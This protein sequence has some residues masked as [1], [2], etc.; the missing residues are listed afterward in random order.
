MGEESTPQQAQT[1]EATSAPVDN[2]LYPDGFDET[3]KGHDSIKKFVDEKGVINNA[4]VLKSY[5]HAQ[6][7]IGKDKIP[8]PNEHYTEENWNEFFNKIGRPDIS[9]YKIENKVPEGLTAD[10][11]MFKNFKETA[12]KLGLLP[13]QAQGISD[14]YN[15]FIAETMKSHQEANEKELKEAIT[16]LKKEWGQGYDSKIKAAEAG[17]K[18]FATSEEIQELQKTGLMDSPI[19]T[20][21]FA[22]IGEGLSEDVFKGEAKGSFGMT[23]EQALEKIRTFYAKDHP[24][25]NKRDPQNAFYREEMVRLHEIAGRSI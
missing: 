25:M 4:N 14:F 3:L 18:Q 20:K 8:V 12:H 10:D 17:L 15:G 13:K 19:V 7:L 22:K 16:S 23:P 2:I 5:I 21:L 11:N 6:N 9:E 1:P 24:Y